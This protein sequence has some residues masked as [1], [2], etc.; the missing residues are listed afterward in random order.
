MS[1]FKKDIHVGALV[2]VVE[3]ESPEI[4]N[5][6]CIYWPVCIYLWRH[7]I[8]FYQISKRVHSSQSLRNT[9]KERDS[10]DVL[11]EI[12]ALQ[13]DMPMFYSL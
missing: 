10:D 5:K 6:I 8:S 11:D 2:V 13:R 1:P 4:C 12:V 3:F 7:Y 9:E